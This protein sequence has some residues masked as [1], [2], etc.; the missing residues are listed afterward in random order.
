MTTSIREWLRGV[1]QVLLQSPWETRQ[2]AAKC[3]SVV[4]ETRP[5]LAEWLLDDLVEVADKVREGSVTKRLLGCVV[6][7]FGGGE[8][9]N[10][11]ML[12]FLFLFFGREISL[13]SLSCW[14]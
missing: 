5:V 9:N 7:L 13:Q 11:C 2:V 14:P 12:G 6:V 8:S 10:R 1:A 4:V 3:I